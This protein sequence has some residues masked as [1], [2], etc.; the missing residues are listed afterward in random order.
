MQIVGGKPPS[1]RGNGIDYRHSF[2]SSDGE[3]DWIDL[4]ADLYYWTR[5]L[6]PVQ[7]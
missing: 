5:S 2:D 6:R 3:T 4:D 7:V 1:W